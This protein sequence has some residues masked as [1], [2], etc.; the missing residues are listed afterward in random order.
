M[1]SLRTKAHR[2]RKISPTVEA[3]ERRALLATVSILDFGA[4]PDDTVDDAPAIQAALNA[5]PEGGG[6]VLVPVG[7][8]RLGSTLA[9]G[10]ANTTLTGEGPNS[11]LRLMD[12]TYASAISIPGPYRDS[13]DFASRVEGITVSNLTVDGNHNGFQVDPLA[14]ITLASSSDRQRT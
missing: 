12:D 14:G 9:L 5:V 10:R 3:V 13:Y 7:E 4:V 8:F 1:R 11:V 2:S 6:T